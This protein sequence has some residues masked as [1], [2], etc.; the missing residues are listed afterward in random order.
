MFL[1]CALARSLFPAP[2]HSAAIKHIFVRRSREWRRVM[3][4]YLHKQVLLLLMLRVV[5]A[6]VASLS[7]DDFR[8]EKITPPF[9]ISILY[10]LTHIIYPFAHINH[11]ITAQFYH[12]LPPS[13]PKTQ[14]HNA[15]A[16][17]PTMTERRPLGPSWHR[18]MGMHLLCA[19]LLLMLATLTAPSQAGK[20][21]D[22]ERV[23]V[24]TFIP[25]RQMINSSKLARKRIPI[26]ETKV[27]QKPTNVFNV[28]GPAVDNVRKCAH[29]DA[30][31]MRNVL[32]SLVCLCAVRTLLAL[33]YGRT[34]AL[35]Y[36]RS[37]R[38]RCMHIY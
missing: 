30:I 14:I 8:R 20:C 38:K 5:A 18:E 37:S 19:A 12:P 31:R 17:F 21:D 28:G 9:I 2:L 3:D 23:Y 32:Y 10:L 27:R 7:L 1:A 25:T 13:P 34:D 33:I 22:E 16:A 29:I 36:T 15:D 35:S 4:I 26:P 11:I 24:Y 6:A